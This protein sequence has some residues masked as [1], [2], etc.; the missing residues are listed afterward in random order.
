M[1]YFCGLVWLLR[2]LGKLHPCLVLLVLFANYYSTYLLW[3]SLAHIDLYGPKSTHAR[4]DVA[5]GLAE[6]STDTNSAITGTTEGVAAPDS[7]Y[8]NPVGP[9]GRLNGTNQT[10]AEANRA[11]EGV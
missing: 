10:Y 4:N 8:A 9:Q 6:K 5:K 11:Y 3:H 7:V 2:L 1:W